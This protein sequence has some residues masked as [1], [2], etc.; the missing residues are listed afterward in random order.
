MPMTAKIVNVCAAA[1]LA[2]CAALV[3]AHGQQASVVPVP[4]SL[5]QPATP[6][7]SATPFS[8]TAPATAA[9]TVETA[10]N[11][12]DERALRYYASQ[13]DVAHMAAEIRRL[14][15][16]S[17]SWSPP[18]DLMA[19]AAPPKDEKELWDLFA[20]GRFEDIRQRVA[21]RRAED[22]QWRPSSDFIAKFDRAQLRA[23]LVN[24]SN[25]GQWQTVLVLA[26]RDNGLLVCSNIDAVWRVA[27]AFAKVGNLD[28]A[29]AAYRYVLAS[30][31]SP[32]DRY[33]TVQKASVLVPAPALEA[34]LALGQVGL[35]GKNEFEGVR[36]DILR[37]RIGK[38]AA[39]EAGAVPPSP[40]ELQ[41]F[42]QAAKLAAAAGDQQLLGWYYYSQ[43]QFD[44]AAGWFAGALAIDQKPKSA[45]GLTLALREGGKL[46]E[47]EEI[48]FKWQS[49]D[50]L[51]AKAYVETVA[52][53]LTAT[54]PVALPE[55]RLARFE[56]VL[57]ASHSAVGAQ[58]YG[59]YLFKGN[60]FKP[61]ADWFG[62]SLTWSPSEEA[63]MGL[64]V[65]DLRLKD[66]AGARVVVQTYAAK[67]PRLAELER[68]TVKVRIARGPARHG[69][70][71]GGGDKATSQ[72]LALYKAGRYQDA[73]AAMDGSAAR[74][75][76]PRDLSVLRGWALVQSGE[77]QKAQAVFARL[78]KDQS[79]V[80]TRKA[81][82][83]IRARSLPPGLL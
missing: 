33:A 61:A 20:E 13:N 42:E 76:E 69:S 81:I 59:W 9:V 83:V 60:A 54:P 32:A 29:N 23:A 12:V 22:P 73:V 49:A 14:K 70:G 16:T 15:A 24:A 80:E 45:E 57:D 47:A 3:P 63:A 62:K 56:T 8:L 65:T 11:T 19:G 43:G 75:P 48:G 4:L 66:L 34:L 46:A 18:A 27:E 77:L 41:S 72:I 31:T 55:D 37:N 7:A 2:S 1:L 36:A 39:K 30:C 79:T 52:K 82:N 64:A 71:G 51:V 40:A 68:A 44:V 21:A 74:R 26:G 10:P 25:A 6:A 53:A 17:P 58:V 38:A 50:P 35:D 67:F 5:D 78:D 28:R